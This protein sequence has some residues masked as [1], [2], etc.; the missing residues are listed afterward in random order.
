MGI[1]FA[2]SLRQAAQ[3]MCCEGAIA[4]GDRLLKIT[5]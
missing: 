4:Q 3:F 2:D 5:S 1:R